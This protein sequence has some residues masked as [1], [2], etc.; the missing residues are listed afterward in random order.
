MASSRKFHE[1]NA[2]KI[3]EWK[4][5]P[6]VN[7]PPAW[8]ERTVKSNLTSYPPEGKSEDVKPILPKLIER[9]KKATQ[10]RGSKTKLASWLGVTPQKV[11]DWISERVEPSG[12]T[13]LKL[14]HWVE[15]QERQK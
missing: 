1:D 2:K 4:K 9:L 14:L 7:I 6:R 15:Q 10:E 11:T 13:T 12:E 8:A 5:T 3:G